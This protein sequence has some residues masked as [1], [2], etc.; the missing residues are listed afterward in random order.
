MPWA[1]AIASP[2][3]GDRGPWAAAW[4][5]SSAVARTA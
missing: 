1:V 2:F 4:A 5:A 3:M